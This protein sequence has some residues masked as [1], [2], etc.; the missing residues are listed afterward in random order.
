MFTFCDTNFAAVEFIIT[1]CGSVQP[2]SRMPLYDRRQNF[3]TKCENFPY[4]GNDNIKLAD[5]KKT[6]F[7][8][9]ISDLHLRYKP[10]YSQYG[11]QASLTCFFA[12]VVLPYC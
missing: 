3:A 12:K 1:M 4:R 10:S 8:S 9:R 5:P 11:G 2:D 7:D 6:H